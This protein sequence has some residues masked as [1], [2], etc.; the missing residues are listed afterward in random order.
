MASLPRSLRY[1]LNAL[2]LSRN[3][4]KIRPMS[5]SVAQPGDVIAFDLPNALVDLDSLSLAWKLTTTNGGGAATACKLSQGVESAIEQIS[6]ESSGYM[7]DSGC[8]YTN[9][10]YQMLLDWTVGADKTPLRQVVNYHT[11]AAAAGF[12]ASEEM[13]VTNWAGFLGSVQPRKFDV[14]L[15]PIRVYVKLAAANKGFVSAGALPTTCSI[16]FS[17]ITAYVDSLDVQDGGLYYEGVQKLMQSKP[18]ELPFDKF[19]TTLSGT[20]AGTQDSLNITLS[21]SSIDWVAGLF[22]DPTALSA[23]ATEATFLANDT[24]KAQYFK[25]GV[26]A[27]TVLSTS[28]F[29]V[30]NVMYPTFPATPA[31]AF[32]QTADAWGVL[33]DTVG[34]SAAWLNSLTNY[35]DLG[36]AH[37]IPF[38]FPGAEPELRLQ[39]G[40][41]TLGNNAGIVWTTE[42]SGNAR[43]SKLMVVKTTAKLRVAPYKQV[44]TVL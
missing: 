31:E 19:Y 30:N 22:L 15:C 35:Q 40:L 17:E 25:R 38:S 26:G 24:Y 6:I 12:H 5:Q 13:V 44:E 14:S 41:N 34:G 36:F 43:A 8:A 32:V 10:I 4:F 16:M 11:K 23:P 29:N 21:A 33:R 27:A 1:Y 39:S 20:P 9:Q 18:L 7:I 37:V 2:T 3:R 42:V 28:Q